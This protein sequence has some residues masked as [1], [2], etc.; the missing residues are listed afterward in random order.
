IQ[1]E[2]GPRA[3]AHA[4]L[5]REDLG[6]ELTA[7]VQLDQQGPEVGDRVGNRR[8]IVGVRSPARQGRLESAAGLTLQSASRCQNRR[9]NCQIELSPRGAQS[10]TTTRSPPSRA[11]AD[12]WSPTEA[13]A[14]A[15]SSISRSPEVRRR[16]TASSA[17]ARRSPP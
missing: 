14:P 9:L 2:A 11:T 8:R 3:R 1:P 10:S 15:R 13:T 16:S 5:E 6:R 12:A 17:S 7:L 4:N